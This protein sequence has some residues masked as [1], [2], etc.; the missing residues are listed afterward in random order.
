MG[1]AGCNVITRRGDLAPA[2][3]LEGDLSLV[4]SSTASHVLVLQ[5]SRGSEYFLKI[6]FYTFNTVLP[7]YMRD[8]VRYGI[9]DE[10][11]KAKGG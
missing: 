11:R 2:S 5:D 6:Y 7:P 4:G 8:D 10:E 9:C 1:R 3:L